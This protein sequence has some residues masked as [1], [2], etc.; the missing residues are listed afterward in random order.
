MS[1]SKKERFLMGKK[2]NLSERGYVRIKHRHTW[3]PV[4]VWIGCQ[5]EIGQQFRFLLRELGEK[6]ILGALI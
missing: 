4:F 2:K 6:W 3:S 1:A 5:R